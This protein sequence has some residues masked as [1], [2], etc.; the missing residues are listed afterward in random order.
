MQSEI[1]ANNTKSL[2]Q[3][4]AKERSTSQRKID[5]IQTSY[6]KE[7]YDLYKKLVEVSVDKKNLRGELA[8]ERSINQQKISQI[9]EAYN[10]DS[11]FWREMLRKKEEIVELNEKLLERER[12][13]TAEQN[14]IIEMNEKLLERERALTAEQN[15]LIKDQRGAVVQAGEMSGQFRR[16]LDSPVESQDTKNRLEAEKEAHA[17]T[18][19]RLKELEGRFNELA[20]QEE[21]R[22]PW[23][24]PTA[25]RPRKVVP[26]EDD[27]GAE[28]PPL[29]RKGSR[30]KKE[31]TTKKARG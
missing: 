6:N 31:A 2:G 30:H 12:A 18:A 19:K 28:K 14:Q 27:N 13:L 20:E 24:V 15:Q 29:I 25:W 10:N 17:R 3:E 5:E 8:R 11:R 23:G 21:S 7:R 22:G 26:V 9:L 4:L 16:A 1:I